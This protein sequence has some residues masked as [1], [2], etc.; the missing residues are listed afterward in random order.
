VIGN[1]YAPAL[2][3]AIVDVRKSVDD[4]IVVWVVVSSAIGELLTVKE[5]V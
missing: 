5:R 1:I 3:P 4:M 2:E